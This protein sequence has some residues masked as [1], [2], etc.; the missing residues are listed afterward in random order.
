M[1]VHICQRCGHNIEIVGAGDHCRD[2]M[3]TR[4]RERD[5][6]LA[7]LRADEDARKKFAA[8]T[9]RKVDAFVL[10]WRGSKGG[11]S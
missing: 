8:D 10:A 5:T 6:C 1:H 11:S 2:C 7:V 9:A 4:H 3:A